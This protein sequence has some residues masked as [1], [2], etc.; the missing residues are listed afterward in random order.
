MPHPGAFQT[1]ADGSKKLT[2]LVW[3]SWGPNGAD[4]T[5]VY[6]YQACEPN[7]A[8]GHRVQLP[9]VVHADELLPASP[10]ANCPAG[11]N[12]YANLVV[13]FP[14]GVPTGE[15]GATNFRFRG[16]PASLYSTVGNDDSGFWLGSLTC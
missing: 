8:A 4:G 1:C 13:A 7:C 14:E 6:S 15:G 5:G 9:A 16:M 3:T 11:T 12:F 2:G 10:A